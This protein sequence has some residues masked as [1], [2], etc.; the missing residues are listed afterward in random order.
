MNQEGKLVFEVR[1]SAGVEQTQPIRGV[2]D[3]SGVGEVVGLEII[4]LRD[5]GGK[6]LLR[7]CD[8]GVVEGTP[9]WRCAYDPEADAFALSV[10]GARS[11]DQ[12]A[13][14]CLL[15]KD[16]GGHL[17]RIEAQVES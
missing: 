15:V 1:P 13:V 16:R 10:K 14:P 3:L 12:R 8:L 5:I 9:E 11:L 6:E 4:N 17:L 2:L 7:G